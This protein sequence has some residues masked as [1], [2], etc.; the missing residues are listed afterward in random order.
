MISPRRICRL[1]GHKPKYHEGPRY[2]RNGRWRTPSYT[3]CERCGT[4]DGYEV[5][6]AGLLERFAWRRIRA[7][8]WRAREAMRT[9]ICI[10]CG[11]PE[12]RLGRK[13]GDHRG[14]IPL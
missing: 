8:P 4:S 7:W 12:R 1:I 9:V 2:L 13:V 10:D 3:R 5:H 14:C 6:R 11:K